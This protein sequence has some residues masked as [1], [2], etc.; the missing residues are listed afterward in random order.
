MELTDKV[1]LVT[2]GSGDIGAAI[3][4]ALATEGC[5]VALTYVG[6]IEGA[7]LYSLILLSAQTFPRLPLVGYESGRELQAAVDAGFEAGDTLRVW[8]TARD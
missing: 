1:A 4:E 6:N 5:D 2:G 8:V 7:E 3:C